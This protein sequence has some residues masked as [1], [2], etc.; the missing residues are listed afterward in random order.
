[1]KKLVYGT[2]RNTTKMMLLFINER[3]EPTHHDDDPG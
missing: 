2:D 3:F 1:M